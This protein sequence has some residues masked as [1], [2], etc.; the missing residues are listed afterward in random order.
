MLL[1]GII[2]FILIIIISTIVFAVK[3]GLDVDAIIERINDKISPVDEAKTFFLHQHTG[4]CNEC[5]DCI[6]SLIGIKYFTE[7]QQLQNAGATVIFAGMR[8][9]LPCVSF[10]MPCDESS[11]TTLDITLKCIVQKYCYIQYGI[12][13]APVMTIWGI[14]RTLNIPQICLYYARNDKEYELL[15]RY[16]EYRKNQII[17]S[18]KP[19][20]D[21]E[22]GEDL[23]DNE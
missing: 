18:H 1:E 7:F 17:E 20:T 16:V 12:S 9:G 2:S 19:V 15:K 14:N 6:Q 8:D 22:F 4:F 13:N 5:L 21:T 23:A 3:H 11:R 10:A